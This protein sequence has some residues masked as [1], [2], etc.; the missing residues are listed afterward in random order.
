[1]KGSVQSKIDGTV[2]LNVLLLHLDLALN[3]NWCDTTA[4]VL[5][6]RW[7][8]LGLNPSSSG[9][10]KP[11]TTILPNLPCGIVMKITA[12]RAKVSQSE[13]DSYYPFSKDK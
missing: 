1:M 6:L 12:E 7:G 9:A 2:D 10:L 5:G 8:D 3:E 11:I 13:L 4:G